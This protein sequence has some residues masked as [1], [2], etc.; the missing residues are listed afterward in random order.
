MIEN[1]TI[2]DMM[3]VARKRFPECKVYAEK[4]DFKGA[5]DI[6]ISAEGF[7]GFIFS[8]DVIENIFDLVKVLEGASVI[9][10]YY[11]RKRNENKNKKD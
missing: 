2:N 4:C 10:N 9:I 6:L 5:H 7:D 11:L 8:T 1:I 3:N